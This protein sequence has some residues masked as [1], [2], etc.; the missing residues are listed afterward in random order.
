QFFEP[1]E[2][3]GINS[4]RGEEER[5]AMNYT[6][7]GSKECNTSLLR[8]GRGHC[9]RCL[10]VPG[11]PGFPI[12]QQV[13]AGFADPAPSCTGANFFTGSGK[14]ALC[15]GSRFGAR[16]IQPVDGEFQGGRTGVHTQNETG[17][18]VYDK[19]HRQLAT[20]VM[21]SPW[22]GMYRSCSASLL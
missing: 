20:S 3:S 16:I 8:K 9:F 13:A 17:H 12:G 5:T 11:E 18:F 19:S 7:S 4:L 2:Q 6:V 21:S 10:T 1:L 15:S 14:Q 22:T